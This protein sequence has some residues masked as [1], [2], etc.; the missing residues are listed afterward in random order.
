MTATD[1][2]H[3]DLLGPPRIDALSELLH[4]NTKISAS[5]RGFVI[6]AET[7]KVMSAG[8]KTYEQS[9]WISLAK[10]SGRLDMPV[11]Q[12][13]QSRRSERRFSGAAL[14]LADLG[15]LIFAGYGL[16]SPGAAHRA[17]PSAGGLFPLELYPVLLNVAGVGRGLC[18]YDVRRHGL[19]RLTT[20]RDLDLLRRAVFVDD[21]IETASTV[22]VIT[23]VF[24]R[25][26]IKY[27]ERG[28]RF[29]LLEAGHVAQN[30]I[31]AAT[32]LGLGSCPIGGFVDDHLND[33]LDLDGLDEA[34]LYLVVVG[35]DAASPSGIA[36]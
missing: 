4:E 24:G 33:L 8:F 2:A 9:D 7:M 34:V 10:P 28:Y 17:A 25:T 20:G 19:E 1:V 29:A 5:A 30:I 31:L 35:A 27:G 18:H 12:A 15:A 21:L 36:D 32:A 23:A 11:G 13:I 14:S 6:T 3:W 22:I 16:D 26:K